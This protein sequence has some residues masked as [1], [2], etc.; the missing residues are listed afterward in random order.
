MKIVY[1][2]LK[3]VVKEGGSAADWIEN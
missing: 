3:R 1:A 2:L